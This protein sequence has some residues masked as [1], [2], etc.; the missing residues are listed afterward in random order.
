M[1]AVSAT[2]TSGRRKARAGDVA[3]SD[4]EVPGAGLEPA[5]LFRQRI[6]SPVRLPFRHPGGEGTVE[7]SNASS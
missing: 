5:R 2:A 7:L 1:P 4:L 3:A 6:L